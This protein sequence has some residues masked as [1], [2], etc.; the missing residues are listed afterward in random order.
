MN[1]SDI[2]IYISSSFSATHNYTV[3]AVNGIHPHS[4]VSVYEPY[5]VL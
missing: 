5:I 3:H 4:M 2:K 1:E